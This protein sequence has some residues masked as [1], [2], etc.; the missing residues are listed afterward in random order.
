MMYLFWGGIYF[1]PIN[2]FSLYWSV[3]PVCTFKIEV[4]KYSKFLQGKIMFCKRGNPINS[5]GTWYIQTMEY[6][7]PNINQ[8][9]VSCKYKIRRK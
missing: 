3:A 8:N 2:S 4:Q 1:V 5:T 6:I 9:S 7:N